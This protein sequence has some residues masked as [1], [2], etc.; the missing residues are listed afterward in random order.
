MGKRGPAPKPT[1]LRILHGN[2]RQH[3][4]CKDEVRP[5][6]VDSAPQPPE[7]LTAKGKEL[8]VTIAAR[9]KALNLLTEIDLTMLAR[10]C[11]NLEKWLKAKQVMDTLG[12][13][14]TMPNGIQANRPEVS[15]YTQL[16]K[17]LT[18]LEQQFGM[19]PAARVGLNVKQP[20]KGD[21]LKRRLYG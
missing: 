10:Y 19:S 14:Y 8:W 3:A 7:E 18:R 15:L 17:D 13:T 5:P 1:E 20:D 2:P 6:V 21:D 16:G 9:L 12:S 11:D 4:I